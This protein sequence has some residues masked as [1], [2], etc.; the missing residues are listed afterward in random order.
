[1]L[2][3]PARNEFRM[4]TLSHYLNQ[5]CSGY[6]EL[7]DWPM[8]KPDPSVRDVEP[9]P[10]PP[11]P[12]ASSSFYERDTTDTKDK[13]KK[14]EKGKK[15]QRGFYSDGEIITADYS[16]LSSKTLTIWCVTLN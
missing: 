7:P 1:M 10:E 16:R 13:T 8:E 9:P 3:L 14:G 12:S 6:E 5:R 15:K 2:L 11:K 4:N